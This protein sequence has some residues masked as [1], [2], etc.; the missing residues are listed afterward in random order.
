MRK[1]K[2]MAK[3]INEAPVEE[4]HKIAMKVLKEIIVGSKDVADARGVKSG[5]AL[6]AVIDESKLKWK[7]VVRRVKH[8]E[9]EG[10]IASLKESA[11]DAFLKEFTPELYFD[12]QLVR[13]S[14]AMK[15]SKRKARRI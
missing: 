2:E 15:N 9:Y 8:Y 1:A 3:E 6:L 11:F 12:I 14:V 4:R 5:S 7:A 10:G 13:S